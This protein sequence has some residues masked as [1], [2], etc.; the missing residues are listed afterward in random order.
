MQRL[1]SVLK[2]RVE[3]AHRTP[4]QEKKKIQNKSKKNLTVDWLLEHR[5]ELF[6]KC[7][8]TYY[9]AMRDPDETICEKITRLNV[10]SHIYFI[11]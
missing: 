11:L 5:P 3:G 2:R 7:H 10:Y 6:K 1:R 4:S 9:F 8:T